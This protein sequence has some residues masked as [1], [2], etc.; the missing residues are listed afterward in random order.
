MEENIN[1]SKLSDMIL[2]II[3]FHYTLSLFVW[4]CVHVSVCKNKLY[5]KNIFISIK[6]ESETNYEN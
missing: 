3:Q 4:V 5:R 6:S 2:N 1:E